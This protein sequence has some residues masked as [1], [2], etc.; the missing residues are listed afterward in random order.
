MPAGDCYLAMRLF[1]HSPRRGRS[2]EGSCPSDT[3]TSTPL[4][5]LHTPAQTADQFPLRSTTPQSPD[6]DSPAC[7][8]AAYTQAPLDT[9]RTLQEPPQRPPNATPSLELR[10]ASTAPVP[11]RPDPAA[12]R[13]FPLHRSAPKILPAAHPS[14]GSGS[15]S[16]ERRKYPA[17][18]CPSRPASPRTP[19]APHPDR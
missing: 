9:T 3:S 12:L 16:D 7:H 6:P 19:S 10:R 14:S 1:W 8:T 11:I 18:C 2:T 4:P 13:N 17:S 15:P 5:T